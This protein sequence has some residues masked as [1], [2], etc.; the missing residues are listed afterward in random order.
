MSADRPLSPHLQVYRL[1]PAALLSI[2]HRISG[3]LLVAAT[4]AFSALVFAAAYAPALYA[5]M[6]QLLLSAPGTLL[7]ALWSFFLSLHLCTGVRHLVWDTARGVDNASVRWSN[8]LVAG[9]ALAL[10]AALWSGLLL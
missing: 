9:A 2:S 1:P 3:A 7:L 5:R 10:T 8:Y 6:L 4:L